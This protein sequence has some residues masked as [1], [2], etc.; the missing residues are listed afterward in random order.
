MTLARG[1]RSATAGMVA[2]LMLAALA[3][4]KE[5]EDLT[6]VEGTATPDFLADPNAP[7]AGTNMVTLEKGPVSGSRITLDVVV[8]DVSDAVSGI[9]LKLT[10][11]DTFSKFA[12]CTDGT[13]FDSGSCL[14]SEPAPGSGEVFIGRSL[15][16]PEPAA[17]IS[18][19]EVIVRLE[20]LTFGQGS[21]PITIEAQNL[22]GGDASA[23]LDANGDPIFVTWFAGDISGH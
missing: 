17:P 21:G 23:L 19:S 14:F 4:C 5:S 8:T 3:A 1:N 12:K 22:G 13:V 11:P 20:F 18:G 10:Y 15:L 2:L 6:S 7:A 16:A 9:A